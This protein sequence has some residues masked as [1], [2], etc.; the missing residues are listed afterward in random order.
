MISLRLAN[1]GDA[2]LM[3][4]WV[5]DPKVRKNSFQQAY[6]SFDQHIDWFR[7]RLIDVNTTIVIL[8]QNDLAIGQIRFDVN[9]LQV[10]IDYSIDRSYRGKGFGKMLIEKGI[11]FFRKKN[12]E[13][14]FEFN[15]I[16]KKTN[17]ASIKVFENIGFRKQNL[18]SSSY[19][20]LLQVK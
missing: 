1:L 14:N 11:D 6:I 16:V 8:E 3:F 7:K 20:Y 9:N 17:V 12:P 19:L 18:N 5:N 10:A 15:A 13:E 4:S 2:E